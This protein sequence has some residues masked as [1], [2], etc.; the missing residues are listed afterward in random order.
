MAAA[1]KRAAKVRIAPY[2]SVVI[3]GRAREA[4]E[5]VAVSP[6]DAKTL[7]ADGYAVDPD[8]VVVVE[9]EPTAPDADAES[10]EHEANGRRLLTPRSIEDGDEERGR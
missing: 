1:A 7:I 8:A 2:R 9:Q 6:D 3:D 5:L 4:G 10:A